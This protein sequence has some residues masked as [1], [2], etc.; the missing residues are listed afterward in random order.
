MVLS[1]NTGRSGLARPVTEQYGDRNRPERDL[2]L[3]IFS[4]RKP[5][6]SRDQFASS[7][8]ACG[9]WKLRIVSKALIPRL[10][11]ACTGFQASLNWADLRGASDHWT[12]G[13]ISRVPSACLLVVS[14]FVMR[15]FV[16]SFQHVDTGNSY[17]CGYLK[18]KGLTEVS[19]HLNELELKRVLHTQQS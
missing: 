19:T 2:R 9:W 16:L 10:C 18:I 6:G 14:P 5:R 3:K 12:R 1:V 7:E 17:L 4:W 13:W 15:L 11:R 8:Q